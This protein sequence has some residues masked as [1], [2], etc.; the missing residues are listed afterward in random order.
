[1]DSVLNRPLFRR[2]EARDRLNEMAGVQGFQVGG[3]ILS[4]MDVE[5]RRAVPTVLPPLAPKD[6]GVR[7][8]ETENYGSFVFNPATNQLT[9][10]QGNLVPPN[11][12]GAILQDAASVAQRRGI[13]SLGAGTS[14]EQ[15]AMSGFRALSTVTP[16]MSGSVVE[17]LKG[18]LSAA[19]E[20]LASGQEQLDVFGELER[21]AQAPFPEA[22]PRGPAGARPTPVAPTGLPAGGRG[23]QA[24]SEPSGTNFVR[25]EPVLP[26]GMPPAAGVPAAAPAATPK[27]PAAG[28]S[29]ERTG[30][31]AGPLITN[32]AEVAA[33]LNAPDPAVRERTVQDFMN[34]FT[35]NAPKY[36]GGDRNMMKAMIGF[37]IAAGESP[38]AMT[39][40]AQGLQAG[41]QMFLQDKAAKDEFDRQLQLSA[42]QYGLQEVGKERERGRQPLTFVALEDTTYK[43][44]PVKRGEQV[45]IPYKEIE[46]NGGVAPP[47]FGDTAMATAMAERQQGVFETLQKAF[48]SKQMS[49]T[50]VS[51]AAQDY[52][53]AT[54]TAVA[55][56]R[57]IDFME[58][59]LLKVGEDG[60]ITGLEG[61]AKDFASK[62]AAAAGMEDI[63]QEFNDR[64]EALAFVKLG[65]Q[66]LIPA[67]LSGVQTANS[68]SNRDIEI[69]AEAYVD[70]MMQGGIFS[71]STITEEKLMNSMKAALDLLQSSR[72]SA[73]TDLASIERRLA[74]R[75]LKSGS[76][77]DPVS[78]L[79]VIEP[80][81]ELIPGQAETVPSRLGNLYRSDD[82]VYDIM[83]PGG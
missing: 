11:I 59:A 24:T 75:Y 65:F 52:S 62:L 43:G 38:N 79:T 80:Y 22:V 14:A 27:A 23:P 13:A 41:A 20:A 77:T 12:A 35:A 50:D 34:E 64:S 67:A 58:A 21:A 17:D 68:I 29:F 5:A 51:A 46:R 1:M 81:Q 30:R 32:P 47:G 83:R 7:V 55:A 57:G 6:M 31:G 78:A 44:R 25:P 33:G 15:E 28:P 70:S 18:D 54:G 69:L 3:P 74:G 72:Q 40:I 36:E 56:Q 16:S 42:M 53:R 66:N 61:S 19:G 63:N 48:E 73:L 39:N 9:D 71:M 45:Y 82:G 26:S 37:A 76:L 60:N 4:G 49:D 2:R 10:R 8:I